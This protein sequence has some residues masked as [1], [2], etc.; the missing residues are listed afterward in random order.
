MQKKM[1]LLLMLCGLMQSAILLGQW[2]SDP[3]I[4]SAICTLGG[5]QAIPKVA[6]GPT[7]DVYISY[8]SNDAGNYDVRLQRLDVDGNILWAT[9]GLLISNHTAM[10]W[11]T[12]WDM[13]VDDAN[14]AILTFQDIRNNG[15]NNI[16]AYRIAPDGTFVWGA[17]GLELSNSTTMDAAPKVAVASNGDA[18]ITWHN[19]TDIIMQRISASGDLL[20]GPTGITLSGNDNYTWPQPIAAE[21]GAVIVKYFIDSGPYWAPDRYVYAQ[22]YGIDG[23]ALW[24]EPT[25]ISEAGGISAWTQVFSMVS[26]GNNGFF[27]A[28]HEDRDNNMDADVYVQHVLSDGTVSWDANGLQA[29]SATNSEHFYPKLA[30]RNSEEMLYVY[31]NEMD[32]DQNNRGI[33]LQKID[34]AGTLLW[35]ANGQTIIPLSAEDIYLFAGGEDGSK[36]V[37]FYEQGSNNSIIKAVAV[38]ANGDF[39][40]AD[41][42]VTLCSVSSG[43]V[44][45]NVAPF[46]NGQWIASWED[47]R[48]GASDIYA[49]NLHADG[50]IGPGSM[51]EDGFISGLVTIDQG[52]GDVSAA[53]VNA[54]TSSAS[55]APDGAYTLELPAGT[56]TVSA[57]LPSY[58]AQDASDIEVIS[59]QTTEDVNFALCYFAPPTNV[60]ADPATGLITWEPPTFDPSL[61]FQSY[62]LYFEGNQITLSQLEYQLTGLINGQSYTVGLASTYNEGI[63]P[64][65]ETTFTYTGTGVP[66]GAANLPLLLSNYPNPFNPSTAIYYQLGMEGP[67]TLEVYNVRGQK[68]KTLVDRYQTSGSHSIIW[69]GD[70]ENGNP[71]SSGLYFYKLHTVKMIKTRKMVLLE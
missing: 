68:I 59:G 18:V 71:V 40:W 9:D 10:T 28:W 15:N 50:S 36:A 25:V 3:A 5:E 14:H 56:Y 35:G 42:T 29:H 16:Y 19:D 60:L 69:N 51:P 52:P 66:T 57:T 30:Y 21:D 67:I 41:Q 65:I 34:S 27:I 43:K 17:D 45:P 13:T 6:T 53:I 37:A 31:W 64:I 54:S 46:A 33:N 58:F 47:N 44:H 55:P 24:T 4:N 22:K 63:S 1:I 70:D 2:S 39:P 11:L 20:W 26:D 49:Q 12:D 23:T 32:S 38:D 62:S 61:T 48:N 7:A 8:F